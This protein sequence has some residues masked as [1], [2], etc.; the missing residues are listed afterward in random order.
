M[1]GFRPVT[2]QNGVVGTVEIKPLLARGSSDAGCRAVGACW[3]APPVCVGSGS[4]CVL[5]TDRTVPVCDLAVRIV[6]GQ[7]KVQA[8]AT[9]SWIRPCGSSIYIQAD[10]TGSWIRPKPWG[11]GEQVHH[12][13]RSP[14]RPVSSVLSAS[15]V[16]PAG[17]G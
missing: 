17:Q 15:S 13:L 11:G 2:A 3:G 14:Y 1:N 16:R 6:K 9:G 10:A 5:G 12:S 4:F 8:D 7:Y